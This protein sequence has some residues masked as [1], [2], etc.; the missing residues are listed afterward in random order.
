M[1]KIPKMA[2]T[3]VALVVRNLSAMY[4]KLIAN[5]AKNEKLR[6]RIIVGELPKIEVQ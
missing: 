4:I 2:T 1:A 3:F 6:R 5:I